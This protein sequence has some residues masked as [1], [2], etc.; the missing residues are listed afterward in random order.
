MVHNAN[1]ALTLR[2]RHSQHFAPGLI[3]AFWNRCPHGDK[4]NGDLIVLQ[5]C[6]SFRIDNIIF[7][8]QLHDG[9]LVEPDIAA[10]AQDVQG[11][12]PEWLAASDVLAHSRGIISR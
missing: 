6:E 1:V 8:E 12:M 11:S 10:I 4:L 3:W 2:P 7:Y 9:E 5:G